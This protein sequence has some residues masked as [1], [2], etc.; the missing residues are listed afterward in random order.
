[1]PIEACNNTSVGMIVGN[2]GK[3][4]LIERKKF[5][6]GFACPAGHVDEGETYEEAAI[7]ELQEEVGLSVEKLDTVFEGDMQNI[8]RRPGGN[9]HHWKVFK[10]SSRGGVRAS[11]GETKSYRWVT[12]AEL[13]A[14]IARSRDYLAGNISEEDW[15]LSPGLELVWVEILGTIKNNI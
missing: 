6:F 11:E 15:R 8:C 12:D 3:L 13:S 7:R 14:L 4:L 9:W 10:V 1:M 2:D 5:P